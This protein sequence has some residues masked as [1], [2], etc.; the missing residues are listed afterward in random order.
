M[1]KEPI[2][3]HWRYIDFAAIAG[4]FNN[5]SIVFTRWHLRL[6]TTPWKL[7]KI[8]PEDSR[9]RD[10][11]YQGS[12]RKDPIAQLFRF[13]TQEEK[14]GEI[15]RI[16]RLDCH[17]WQPSNKYFRIDNKIG[18]YFDPRQTYSRCCYF[19]AGSQPAYPW[20]CS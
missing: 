9:H 11:T 1:F 20:K 19:F 3:H 18:T 6:S 16:F 15:Q 7:P 5:Y 2:N 4:W 8:L 13:P 12:D 17:I 14:N 10:C